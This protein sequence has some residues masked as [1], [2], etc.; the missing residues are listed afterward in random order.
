MLSD[1]GSPPK[2]VLFN[3]KIVFEEIKGDKHIPDSGDCPQDLDVFADTS[4]EE[5]RT[6]SPEHDQSYE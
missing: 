5:D 4:R 6:R 3:Q 2:Q 1:R